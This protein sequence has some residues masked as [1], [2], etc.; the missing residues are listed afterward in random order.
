[1][2][3][4]F[5]PD[6][7]SRYED[8]GYLQRSFGAKTQELDSFVV[9]DLRNF[10]LAIPVMV[11]WIYHLNIQ[12]DETMEPSYTQIRDFLDL[13]TIDDF[14]TLRKIQKRKTNFE[15]RMEM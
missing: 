9:D 7:V 2:D 5:R 1:M 15:M 10:L 8:V 6:L 14:L 13:P 3:S 12:R 11:A 4:F